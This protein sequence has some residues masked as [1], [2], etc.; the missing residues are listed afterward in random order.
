MSDDGTCIDRWGYDYPEHDWPE[1]VWNCVRCDAE[2]Y[3]ESTE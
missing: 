3:E 2:L 1:G